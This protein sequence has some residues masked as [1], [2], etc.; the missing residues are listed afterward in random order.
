[1][2]RLFLLLLPLLSFTARDWQLFGLDQ[3]VTVELPAKPTEAKAAPGKK[4]GRSRAWMLPAPEGVYQL[5]RMP[6]GLGRPDETART[7]YY[8]QLIAYTLRQEHGQLVTLT[9]IPTD[10][11]PS[12]EY[13]YRVVRPGTHRHQLKIV[14]TL[15]VDSVAYS[16]N[17]VP[18]DQQDSLG[19]AGAVQRTRFYNSLTVRP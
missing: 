19:L 16:L 3:R 4:V 11:G 9:A 12:L 1:M 14:R 2:K 17:F 6:T 13:T 8:E 15:V 5:L 7:A 18:A 10:A